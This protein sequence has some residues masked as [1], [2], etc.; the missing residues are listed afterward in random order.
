MGAMGAMSAGAA[1]VSRH[2][3]GFSG[4]VSL[5]TGNERYCPGNDH[6]SAQD[7]PPW[8]DGTFVSMMIFFF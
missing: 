6:I 7:S 2:L 5:V 3:V 8:V 4:E 1:A